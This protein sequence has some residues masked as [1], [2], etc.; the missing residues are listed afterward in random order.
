[1][2][3]QERSNSRRPRAANSTM[4]TI[5]I[6]AVAV[7]LAITAAYW[8]M[9]LA[10][11]STR[12][13][14]LQFVNAYAVKNSSTFIVHLE[15]RNAGPSPA[16]IVAILFN[17]VP[18]PPSVK[19]EEHSFEEPVTVNPGETKRFTVII[20]ENTSIGG[21]KAVSGVALE[22]SFQTALGNQYPRTAVLP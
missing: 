21:G 14:K 11:T 22:I 15:L 12:Y 20:P 13:E 4:A 6:V 8:I 19:V 2:K 18:M 16:T 1:M 3:K 5:I 7:V 9:D 17:G 10:G